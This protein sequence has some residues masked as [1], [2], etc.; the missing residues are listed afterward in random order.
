MTG[1][2]VTFVHFTD[3]HIGDQATDDH[4]FSDTSANIRRFKD[5]LRTLDPRPSFV[6]AT[7]D[8]ANLGDLES[9]R[10]LRLLMADI[11]V[12]V[13]YALGNHDV[14]DGRAAFYEGMLDRT[15]NTHESYDH[16]RLIDGLHVIVLDSSEPGQIGG[17]FTDAQ[18]AWL[19]EALRRHPEAPKL[20]AFHHGP[21]FV[22]DP[23]S[24]WESL[25]WRDSQRLAAAI[26]GH[27]V[28]GIMCGHLHFDRVTSWHGVPVVISI[29]PHMALDPAYAQGGIRMVEGTGFGICRVTPSGMMVNFVPMPSQRTEIAVYDPETLRAKMAEFR[30]AAK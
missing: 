10:K 17:S 27:T 12:P 3:L 26:A 24:E 6:V 2:I 8:L 23:E 5:V 9:Y 13:L 21:A 16:D 1:T 25:T 19:D 18:F 4:L 14:K 20:L 22:E 30:A 28:V 7:G 29:G 11:E 15:E